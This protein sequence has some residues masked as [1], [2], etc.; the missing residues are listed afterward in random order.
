MAQAQWLTAS[1]APAAMAPHTFQIDL[2]TEPAVMV[3]TPDLFK[4]I[5]AVMQ[6]LT[7]LAT[8]NPTAII[9]AI[10]AFLAAL[11]GT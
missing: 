11:M 9:N 5:Q 7:A 1:G 2:P 8:G 10:M 4:L 3:G 6:L